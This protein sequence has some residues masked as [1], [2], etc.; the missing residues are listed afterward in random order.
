MSSIQCYKLNDLSDSMT[1]IIRKNFICIE[2]E[3]KKCSL[4]YREIEKE[5]NLKEEQRK[6]EREATIA[7]PIE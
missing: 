4:E 6:S 1:S 5:R 7:P 2:G 3:N